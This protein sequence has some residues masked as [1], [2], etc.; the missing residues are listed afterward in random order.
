MNTLI[1]S[2]A[3]TTPLHPL[4]AQR[5][6]PRSFDHTH[7]LTG[8]QVTALLEAARWAPSAANSQPWRFA[9]ALR[10]S[11]DHDAVLDIL[12]G[13]NRVWAQDASALIV[14][15]TSTSGPDGGALPWGAY[16][17][18]QAV[19]HLSVQA[20]HEGLA[21]HQM[22]GFDRDRLGAL[23]AAAGATDVAPLVVVAIG[24]RAEA[25]RL[26]EPFAARE[27]AARDRLPVEQLLLSLQPDLV[28]VA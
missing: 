6:S 12:N 26:I 15:A 25:T 28:G 13:S 8:A 5:W 10:D 18:G 22:G 24:R 21:V 7:E 11:A 20:E 4:L 9:V 1:K 14:V 3:T 19:A 23:L 2:A 16:D 17:A 27:V